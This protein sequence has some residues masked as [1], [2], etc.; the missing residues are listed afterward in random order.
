MSQSAALPSITIVT[1]CKNAGAT[2]GRALASVARCTYSRLQYVVIDGGST[3][4]TR[5]QIQAYGSR[6]DKFVSEPDKGISDA[7]NK[8]IA[9][10]DGDYQLI[11]H[12]DDTLIPESLEIMVNQARGGAA[13]VVCGSVIVRGNSGIIR[14]FAP[15]PRKLVK[16]MSVPHMGALIRKDAWEAVGGYDLRRK[17]AMDHL[18]MLRIL[19]R[20]GIEAFSTVDVVVANYHLGGL[21]DKYV[22]EGFREVRDNL[23]EEGVGRFR[24]NAAFL[25]L[26]AKA[27]L[28]RLI[29]SG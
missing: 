29:R 25:Q 9:L 6:I 23:I 7:L 15:E 18:L 26:T 22:G 10:A 21:S 11:V 13:K 2:I 5:E 28:A 12:A 20:F 27:R 24:A 8:G 19:N 17:I 16:K 14:T 4:N 3:D 1:V